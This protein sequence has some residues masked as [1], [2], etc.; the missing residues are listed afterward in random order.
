MHYIGAM[1]PEAVAAYDLLT[2]PLAWIDGAGRVD[3]CNSAFAHW[4]GVSSKRL[5]GLPLAALELEG[6]ALADWLA[7]PSSAD[8][9]RLRRLP[10]A[11]PGSDAASFADVALSR[12][13]GGGWLLEA[14]PVVEFPGDD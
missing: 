11:F 6:A 12:R 2:T 9:S 1:L 7:Q 3:G 14:H 4:L 13:E 5:A 10:L 8:S